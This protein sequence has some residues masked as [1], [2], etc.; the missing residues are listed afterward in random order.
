MPE[1]LVKWIHD[2]AWI[3]GV[4][5]RFVVEGFKDGWSYYARLEYKELADKTDEVIDKW[6]EGEDG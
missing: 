2:S 1:F 3:A 6:A 4:A 5:T